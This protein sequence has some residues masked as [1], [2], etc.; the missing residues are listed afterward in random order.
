MHGKIPYYSIYMN[1][2]RFTCTVH[3]ERPSTFGL[4]AC[5][6]IKQKR[7]VKPTEEVDELDIYTI[8]EAHKVGSYVAR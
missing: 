5:R 7:P 1:N 2:L 3:G 8:Q 6:K 4:N